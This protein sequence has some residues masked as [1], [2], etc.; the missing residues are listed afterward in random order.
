MSGDRKQKKPAKSGK[1]L[2]PKTVTPAPAL[3][4]DGGA[5]QG[6][7]RG[8][9]LKEGKGGVATPKTIIMP[10]QQ[11]DKVQA[12]LVEGKGSLIDEE[13]VLVERNAQVNQ[14]VSTEKFVLHLNYRSEW[15]PNGKGEHALAR[16]TET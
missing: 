12:V 4:E 10:E 2:K 5:A 8:A 7:A 6:A 1:P 9:S 14:N 15:Q 13:I 11:A 16:P 3:D